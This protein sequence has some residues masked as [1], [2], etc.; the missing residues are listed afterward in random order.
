MLA[1]LAEGQNVFVTVD[2]PLACEKHAT[3][4]S[5]FLTVINGQRSAFF[6]IPRGFS[7]TFA[8]PLAWRHT[9]WHN[10]F[11]CPESY[12]I[13]KTGFSK[14]ARLSAVILGVSKK[15]IFGTSAPDSTSRAV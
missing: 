1:L 10:F 2:T 15:F 12:D 7:S 11:S 9:E 13:Q 4:S 5:D 8:A 14:S 3:E 6:G